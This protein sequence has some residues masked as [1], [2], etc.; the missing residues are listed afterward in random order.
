M[1]GGY[2][3]CPLALFLNRFGIIYKV[4]CSLSGC[5]GR[6]SER[7][8]IGGRELNKQEVEYLGIGPLVNALELLI[9]TVKFPRD[10]AVHQL[11][12]FGEIVRSVDLWIKRCRNEY[13]VN[14]SHE[15]YRLKKAIN[16]H[17]FTDPDEGI[18]YRYS[19]DPDGS[20]HPISALPTDIDDLVPIAVLCLEDLKTRQA[21]A[22]D[23]AACD[24]G[25]NR[26]HKAWR[27]GAA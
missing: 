7:V 15:A 19:V 22:E 17:S 9:H 18:E 27:K 25:M 11:Q 1:P 5:L 6:G 14:A 4:N 13:E 3:G 23:V 16:T 10:R 21:D 20:V 8:F 12:L 26:T 2:S 24:K